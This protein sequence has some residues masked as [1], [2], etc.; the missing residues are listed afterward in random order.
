MMAIQN[1]TFLLRPWEKGD[2]ASLTGHANNFKV[3]QNVRDC[4]PHPYTV[5][6]GRDFIELALS[7]PATQDFAIVI[8]G[9]AVGG[10]GIVPLSDVERFSAEIG[11]WIG[12]PFWNKGIVTQAVQTMT[13]YIFDHT[14]INRLFAPVFAHNA[15]SA[16]VLEKSGFRQVGILTKAAFKNNHFVDMILY[17]LVK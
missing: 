12:E 14:N 3:W 6:D 4:F 7:K 9:N 16:R 17:E 8:D 5:T 10:I 2:A 15:A 1:E 11:Y 13:T